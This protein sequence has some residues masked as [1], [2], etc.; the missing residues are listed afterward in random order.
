MIINRKKTA[1]FFTALTG[2][3]ALFAAAPEKTIQDPYG[4]CSHISHRAPE[5]V[6][7]ELTRMREA[8]INWVRTDFTWERIEKKPGR[9]NFSDFD[10]T[11]QLAKEQKINILPI[12]DY[13]VPWA[14]PAWKH[15]DAWNEYVRRTVSRY[16][17]DLRFW[18]V[19]NEQNGSNFWRDTAS[20]KNYAALLK[21]TYETIKKIDPNLTVLYGGTSG[22]PLAF[23][24]ESLKAGAGD[25]FDVMNIHPYHWQGIPEQ[26]IRQFR[27][28]KALM[29][30]YAVHKPI[31][32][33]EV[34][35]STAL[36]SKF[37]Q[38]VLPPVFRRAGI[39]PAQ[40]TMAIVN[41]PAN[42]F[43]QEINFDFKN[44]F[45]EFKAFE[46]VS[47]EKLNRLDPAK[48][49]VLVPAF[50]EAF[51]ARHIPAL[52]NYVKRGGTLLLPAG[53]PFF[54]DLRQNKQGKITRVQVGDKYV[55]QFHI[56]WEAYWTGDVPEKETYQKPAAEFA[57][58][59]EVT[60][61]PTGRFLHDRNLKPGDRFIPVI[62][63]GTDQY[64]GVNAALYQLNSDLKG[65]IIV[66]TSINVVESVSKARQA[67]LLPRTY[68]IALAHGIERIFWYNFRS[69][70]GQPAEREA[71]F[72]ICQW[73]LEPLP[74][75]R[76]Y[77][78][79]T[80]LCPSG[81]T[82]PSLCR[83][84]NL[85]LAGWTRGDGTRI[86]ALWSAFEPEQ[87]QLSIKGEIQQVINHLGEPQPLPDRSVTAGPS[88]LYLVG[89]E[90]VTLQ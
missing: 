79:L 7:P 60:F 80:K 56:G 12:L 22:V 83:H 47:F 48:Y 71:H 49:P 54:Y 11:I 41:D 77:Q 23:I 3:A 34:G 76:A 26:M 50:G 1:C 24:E 43:Q 84:G 63:A 81:S 62:E 18:E 38:E 44:L 58:Q 90:L 45:P 29:N 16:A 82:T 42:G 68:L 67:E 28:L 89:P 75:F 57:G 40:S 78:T 52:L 2:M 25:Y 86:W 74:S 55:A 69:A 36:P 61:K 5:N 33:T 59:F 70:K 4:V 53:L 15:P 35:W 46:E 37:Y 20:G 17:K 31:W 87:V 88:L 85:Y 9:W 39:D 10:R 72:G 30:R 27:E 13:D 66:C 51:P 21:R 19:W 73:N 32:I 65:N 6:L 14:R 64:R 8:H